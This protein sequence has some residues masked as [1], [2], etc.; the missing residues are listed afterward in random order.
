MAVGMQRETIPV[1][2]SRRSRRSQAQIVRMVCEHLETTY[3]R[4]RLGNPRR[5]LDDLFFILISNRTA[6]KKAATTYRSFKARFPQGD[7]LSEARVADIERVLRPAGLSLKKA[8]QIRGIAGQ[9]RQD[10]GR[11]TLRPLLIQPDADVL[12]YLSQLPGV[13]TKVAYCVMMYTMGRDVLPVDVHV[14]R[15]CRRL[16]W[17]DKKRADQSHEVLAELVPP[18]R[19]FAFHIDCILLGRK[20]CTPTNPKHRECAIEGYCEYVARQREEGC[21]G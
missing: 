16:G 13:S 21:K 6:P 5:P 20:V 2:F 3:G 1:Q 18:H 14:H 8:G 7:L 15:V 12:D 10:F 17:L 9:L 19:R 11:V 4:P